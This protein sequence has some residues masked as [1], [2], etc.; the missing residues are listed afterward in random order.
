MNATLDALETFGAALDAY[1]TA[2]V[3]A[4]AELDVPAGTLT[5]SFAAPRTTWLGQHLLD[6]WPGCFHGHTHM[7][8]AAQEHTLHDLHTQVVD[9]LAAVL[10]HPAL[11]VCIDL[12]DG[13]YSHDSDG[14]EHPIGLLHLATAAH[15]PGMETSYLTF[16]AQAALVRARLSPLWGMER[17]S[18]G[19]PTW[20]IQDIP[21]ADQPVRSR[22][23]RTVRAANW[24]D[25]ALVD[26]A[27]HWTHPPFCARRVF[28][29]RGTEV[30]M[31]DPET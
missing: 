11:T 14:V 13:I 30:G 6:N 27:W 12:M 3:E 26:A 5:P 16:A 7:A 21:K 17:P 15:L 25:A 2:L 19:H 22:P 24:R 10:P 8:L 29:A 31:A 23:M 18:D 28:D 9:G 4:G 1:R 20:S